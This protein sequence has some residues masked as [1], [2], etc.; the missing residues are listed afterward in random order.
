MK[1]N[2]GKALVVLVAV[3]AFAVLTGC[4]SVPSADTADGLSADW[5]A[6]MTP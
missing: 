4:A 1:R 5:L 3:V 6:E 2:Q